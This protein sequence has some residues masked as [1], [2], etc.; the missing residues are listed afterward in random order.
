MMKAVENIMDIPVHNYV[1][2]DY[3]AVENVVDII[4]GVEVDVPF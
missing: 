2:V 4:G 3:E 1:T